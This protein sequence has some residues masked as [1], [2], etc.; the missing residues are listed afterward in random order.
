MDRD[1]EAEGGRKRAESPPVKRS[2]STGMELAGAGVQFGLTIL[3]F[4]FGGV[5]LDKHLGTS[6][7]FTIGCTFVGAAGGLYSMY[8]RAIKADASDTRGRS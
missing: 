2:T 8:R 5:W 6:P 1:R 3:V 4:V 7:W